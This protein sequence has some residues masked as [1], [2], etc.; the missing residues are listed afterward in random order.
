MM[1]QAT[2]DEVAPLYGRK[3]LV[4]RCL[5]ATAKVQ[6]GEP[7]SQVDKESMKKLEIE[8]SNVEKAQRKS[9]VASL[10]TD[11]ASS[12]QTIVEPLIEARLISNIP[13][14]KQYLEKLSQAVR[15]VAKGAKLSAADESTL[16]RFL[17]IMSS[18]VSQ[19]LNAVTEKNTAF[20]RSR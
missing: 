4:E 19:Y 3:L 18:N 16:L 15:R 7:L 5:L 20:A 13:E 9:Q 12:V 14:L 10:T 11:E 17:G 2:F 6:S 1:R 8:L